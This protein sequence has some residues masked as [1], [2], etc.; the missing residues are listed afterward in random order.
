[1]VRYHKQIFGSKS[2]LGVT[3]PGIVGGSDERLSSGLAVSLV[4]KGSALT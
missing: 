2:L 3:K 4:Y 1:L